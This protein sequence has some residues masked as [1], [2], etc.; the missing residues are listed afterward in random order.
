MAS[1]GIPV[2]RARASSMSSFVTTC[3]SGILCFICNCASASR[4]APFFIGIKACFL[5]FMVFHCVLMAS[6]N[7]SESLSCLDHLFRQYCFLLLHLHISAGIVN[8]INGLVREKMV[9]DQ[10][11]GEDHSSGNGLIGKLDG[12]KFFKPV[13]FNLQDFDSC[14]FCRWFYLYRKKALVEPWGFLKRSM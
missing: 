1:I 2:H 6:R 4:W 5:K 14:L 11:V 12:M 3:L 7:E 10:A 9:C 8:Y 13:F